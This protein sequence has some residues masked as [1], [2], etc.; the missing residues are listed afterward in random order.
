LTRPP[1]HRDGFSFATD[2]ELIKDDAGHHPEI[3][4]AA[5][6]SGWLILG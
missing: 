1:R 4:F 5:I 2:F 3:G 6:A